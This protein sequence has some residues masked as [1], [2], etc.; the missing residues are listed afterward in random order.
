MRFIKPTALTAVPLVFSAMSGVVQ[1]DE[2]LF[3]YIKGAEPMPQGAS[4]AYLH[5]TQRSDKGQGTYQ[6][7]DAAAEYER[8]LTDRLSASLYLKAMAI[9]TSGL[10][11][12]G[13][14]P[15]DENY[16]LRFS[17]IEGSLKYTF[18]SP[19][20][21]DF[22]LATYLSYSRSWLDPHSGQ[23]KDKNTVELKLLL[24]KYFLD[25]QLIW[26]GNV[27][28]ESTMATR[29]AIDELPPDFEWTTDPEM[30]I[31]FSAGT[32]LTYR[33]APGWFAGAE[34]FYEE[35][36]ETEVGLERWSLF[37]GPSIHYGGR[38]WW[39]TLSY[40]PQL[41]GGGEMYADQTETDLHLIEKTEREVRLKIGYNF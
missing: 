37:A 13:Y 26:V 30:E 24:Q 36:H 33:F 22:G 3:G 31:G 6:A 20:L 41:H 40:M 19:A 1:A 27:G 39:A 29:G 5:L 12:D 28:M 38:Q 10:Q 9:D 8:G 4:S 15:K 23:D 21:D 18:L 16:G 11:I 2:N 14:L 35:E 32:G 7:L 34:V 25:G 17:G